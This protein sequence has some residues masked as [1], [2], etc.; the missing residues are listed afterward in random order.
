MAQNQ[1]SEGTIACHDT[2]WLIFAISPRRLSNPVSSD[3]Q[4]FHWLCNLC[5]GHVGF[6]PLDYTSAA[7]NHTYTH[8]RYTPTNSQTAINNNTRPCLLSRH[9]SVLLPCFMNLVSKYFIH[10]A[11]MERRHWTCKNFSTC[12]LGRHSACISLYRLCDNA[13]TAPKEAKLIWQDTYK[14]KLL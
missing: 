3:A 4:L 7:W 12:C 5:H 6:K 2:H 13:K 1:C 14:E 11:M 9:V 8:A 10:S